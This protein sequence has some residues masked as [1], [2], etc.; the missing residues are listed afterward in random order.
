MILLTGFEPFGEDTVNPSWLAVQRAAELLAS[1]GIAV[2]AVELPC[3]F[4][5]SATVLMDAI[6]GLKPEII[7]CTGLAGGRA[8]ISLERVAINCDDARIPDNKGQRPIDVEVIA[9]GPAAYFSS[10]P[11]KTALRNLQIAGI[12]SEVSQSAGTYVCNHLF[13]ALMHS[14]ASKP[15]VRGGFVHLPYLPSQLRAGSETPSMPL[16]AM[17]EG[18][19]IVARTALDTTADVKFA[20]GAIS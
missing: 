18:I 8:G 19:A 4:G 20:A 15:G 1:E 13:Y 5:E 10:L 3:V 14:L 6:M 11:I 2:E 16:E 17:A 12:R 7:V 9:G